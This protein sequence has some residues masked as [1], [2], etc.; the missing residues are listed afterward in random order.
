MHTLHT[1]HSLPT[2]LQLATLL[3]F[4]MIHAFPCS[5]AKDHKLTINDTRV[6]MYPDGCALRINKDM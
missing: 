3:Y 1:L 5:Q 6:M 4:Y 2:I